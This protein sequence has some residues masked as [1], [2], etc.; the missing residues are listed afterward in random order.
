M[1]IKENKSGRITEVR[2]ED[3]KTVWTEED[4]IRRDKISHKSKEELHRHLKKGEFKKYAE[5]TFEIL[6][7]QTV[8]EFEETE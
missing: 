5:K 8:K 4:S 1:I 3:G 2:N 6:T 7:G